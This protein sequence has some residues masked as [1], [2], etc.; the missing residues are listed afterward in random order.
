MENIKE[1]LKSFETHYQDEY[2]EQLVS[3][4][5]EDFI[6]HLSIKHSNNT[7]DLAKLGQE[8]RESQ[9]NYFALAKEAAKFNFPDHVKAKRK[10]LE[11]SKRLEKE[12]DTMCSLIL[13]GT[14][15]KS[16]FE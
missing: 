10:A 7:K 3:G 14:T 9:K 12:F 11:E 13:A 5:I 6:S 15:Q 16:L 2:G 8:M 1:I 4:A